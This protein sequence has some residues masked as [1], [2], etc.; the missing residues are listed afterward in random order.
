MAATKYIT[1]GEVADSVVATLRVPSSDGTLP[2]MNGLEL[3]TSTF[4]FITGGVEG[5]RGLIYHG[6]W[7]IREN[8]LLSVLKMGGKRDSISPRLAML[9]VSGP[10]SISYWR[11]GGI[12]ADIR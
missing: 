1:L 5:S 7:N 11:Q 10:G 6:T 12:Y 8:S 4:Q 3:S 2:E 9:R